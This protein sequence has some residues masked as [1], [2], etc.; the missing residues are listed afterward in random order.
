MQHA[1]QSQQHQRNSTVITMQLAMDSRWRH[2]KQTLSTGYQDEQSRIATHLDIGV[3]FESVRGELAGFREHCWQGVTKSGRCGCNV[4]L[5]MHK[6]F[7]SGFAMFMR[8]LQ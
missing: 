6:H 2:S 3:L 8:C 1:N 5:Q 4:A 7:A